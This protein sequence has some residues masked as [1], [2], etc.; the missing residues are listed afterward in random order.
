MKK[1]LIVIAIIV[2]LA[3]IVIFS[4]GHYD[5]SNKQD[6]FSFAK[7]YGVWAGNVVRNMIDVTGYAIKKPWL[8]Q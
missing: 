2:V 4:N 7:A 3:G 1:A 5:F 6:V 8:P